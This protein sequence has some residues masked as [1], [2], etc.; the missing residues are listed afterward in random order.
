M[1]HLI[2]P[3][4]RVDRVTELT[5]ARLRMLELDALLLDVDCTLKAYRENEPSEEI[6]AWLE[7]LRGAGVGLCLMSNG[8]GHRIGRFA[9]KLDIPFVAKALKPFPFRVAAAVRRLGFP[10]KRTAMVGDQVFAD[11]MAGRLAGLTAIYVH[12]ISPEQEPWYTQLKRAPERVVLRWMN[13][14]RVGG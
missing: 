9:E 12:P 13:P 8:L 14:P 7:E 1:L 11:I 3:H 5:S 10:P 6:R 4:Y 2:A